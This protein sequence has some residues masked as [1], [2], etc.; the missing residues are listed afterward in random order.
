MKAREPLELLALWST[1]LMADACVRLGLPLRMGVAGLRPFMRWMRLAGPVRPVR[2]YGSV[3]VFLELAEGADG[4]GYGDVVVIDNGGRLDE[5]CI[6]DLGVLEL[7][8]AGFGGA[9]VWGAHRHSVALTQIEWP[10]FSLGAWAAGPQ[11]SDAREDEVF[12]SAR[13]GPTQV[14]ADDFVFADEDGCVF[15]PRSRVS[16]IARVAREIHET[17]RRQAARVRSGTSLREQLQFAGFL[18]ARTRRPALTFRE[19]LRSVSGAMES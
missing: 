18:A 5:G 16:E 9:I 17:E 1:P 10:I 4:S 3:E 8:A 13:V 6:G 12:R 2:H 7:R 14:T 15:V 19:H 11:R